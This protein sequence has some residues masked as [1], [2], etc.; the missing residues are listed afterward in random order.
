MQSLRKITLA[1]LL[2]GSIPAYAEVLTLEQLPAITAVA[3]HNAFPSSYFAATQAGLFASAD[4]RSWTRAFD[5]TMP[6]TMVS[7]TGS[8]E[9]YAFVLGTGLVRYNDRGRKWQTI[10]N[11]LGSQVLVNLSA[12]ASSPR[13]LI[14]LNQFKKIIVS[15]NGGEDWHGI[16]GPYR[17]GS[18]AEKRGQQLFSEKCR[19]C[20]G[21]NGVGETYTVQ[22][23][24]DQNFI[25]APALDA[26]EH[27]WHHTDEALVK[28]I[29][30]GSP[31][32]EKMAA[33][34]NHGLSEDS[35]KDLVAYIKSLWTQRELDCQGP[36]HM[37]CMQ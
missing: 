26:S 33:W 30:E 12:D 31:R 25:R 35:A 18:D 13:N 6:V 4:G 23:L 37:Q 16:A 29:L 14:A 19:S 28:T 3:H 22:A 7:E 21:A 2:L 17:A 32:S 27:A 9:L 34:K 20:H 5:S 11:R 36:K 8:G 1:L 24:T 10:N 15:K